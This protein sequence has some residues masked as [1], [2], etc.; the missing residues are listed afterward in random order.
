MVSPGPKFIV[1]TAQS[2]LDERGE[3]AWKRRAFARRHSGWDYTSRKKQ[4]ARHCASPALLPI[5]LN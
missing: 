4:Q 3:R 5:Q 2:L 1:R